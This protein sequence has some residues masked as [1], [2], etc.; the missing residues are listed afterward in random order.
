[1]LVREGEIRKEKG[2]MRNE[3]ECGNEILC[4]LYRTP[5]I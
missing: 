3:K 5:F 4:F 1:M 2:E